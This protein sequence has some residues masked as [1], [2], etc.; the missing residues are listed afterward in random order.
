MSNNRRD[1]GTS[2]LGKIAI[3]VI[4][5]IGGLLI[6][7][8]IDKKTKKQEPIQQKITVDSGEYTK[9]IEDYDHIE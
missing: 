1:S 5:V 4:G 9:N 7:K 8:A 6:G 3:G 2:V